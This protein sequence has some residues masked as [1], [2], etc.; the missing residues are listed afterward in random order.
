MPKI[1][2]LKVNPSLAHFKAHEKEYLESNVKNFLGVLLMDPPE[3]KQEQSPVRSPL[4]EE[5]KKPFIAKWAKKSYH[6]H[7]TEVFLKMKEDEEKKQFT[8][9]SPAARDKT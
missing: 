8:M 7:N 5:E 9:R 1:R 4:D 2:T 6:Y 3:K